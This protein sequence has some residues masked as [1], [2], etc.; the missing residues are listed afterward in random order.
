MSFIDEILNLG[1]KDIIVVTLLFS[2]SF[3]FSKKAKTIFFHLLYVILAVLMFTS[4]TDGFSIHNI[5]I[6]IGLGLLIPQIKFMI[7]FT[8]DT[9][10]TIK[11]MSANTYYFFITL[12]YKT[13]RFIKWLKSSFIMLKV[14]FTT[15]SFNQNDYSSEQNNQESYEERYKQEQEYSKEE[16]S[17][18]NVADEYK[19]FYSDDDYVVLGVSPDDDLKTIKKAYRKLLNIYHTDLNQHLPP[20]ELVI[21]NEITQ[22][23]NSAWGNIERIKK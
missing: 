10:K 9:I 15:F 20:D 19:Q 16:R 17:E 21:Y 11:M 7:I 2:I 4:S 14:F 22:N 5:K 13:I 1:L 3:Y 12:Y 23:L 18:H 6:I 8:Q